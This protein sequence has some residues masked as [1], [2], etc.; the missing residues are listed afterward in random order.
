MD[1]LENEGSILMS[2]LEESKANQLFW[3][4]HTR[5]TVS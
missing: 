2:I 5:I 3:I 4:S 1:T